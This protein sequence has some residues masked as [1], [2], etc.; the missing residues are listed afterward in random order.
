M[1]NSKTT[2]IGGN[3][4]KAFSTACDEADVDV[5]G[6]SPE[7]M[8]E[9]F[10]FEVN[11]DISDEIYCPGSIEDA[12]E[13]AKKIYRKFKNSEGDGP[14]DG[15]GIQLM[16]TLTPIKTLQESAGNYNLEF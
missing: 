16:Y 4:G 12:V 1:E 9:E 2:K 10:D 11:C 15:K 7:E 3:I 14:N 5:P 13:T 6:S 8:S